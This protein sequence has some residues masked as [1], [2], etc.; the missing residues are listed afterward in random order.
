MKRAGEEGVALLTVLLLVA[1]MATLSVAVL[2]DIR[3]SLRRTANAEAVGQARWYALGAET[4]AKAQIARLNAAGGG[5]TTLQGGWHGRPLSFPLEGGT[6]E[7]KVTDGAACFNLNSVVQGVGEVLER[8]EAGVA[9][10]VALAQAL[11]VPEAERLAAALVDW[12][13]VDILRESGGAEDESYAEGGEGWLTAGTLLAEP[14][15]LRAVRGFEPGVYAR[16]RPFVCALPTTELSP[17]NVNTLPPE[18]A[19]L[20]TMLTEGRLPIPAGRR[21]LE[22]RA[23]GGWASTADFWEEPGLQDAAPGEAALAQVGVRSRFFALE[24]EVAY[25]DAEVTASA[26]LEDEGGRVRLVARRWGPQE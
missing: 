6:L 18:K 9:Q 11:D 13:D 14:S 23:P 8:R 1:V 3:F 25:L 17:I 7:A 10:F 19:V 16:L 2:D 15:E 4:L 22:A 26:L 24:T 12:I 20:L 5:R 21:I